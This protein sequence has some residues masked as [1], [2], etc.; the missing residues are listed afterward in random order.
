MRVLAV[1]GATD[2]NSPDARANINTELN[3]LRDELERIGKVTN[4]NGTT[5]LDGSASGPRALKFQ[6]GANGDANNR[7]TVDLKDADVTAISKFG[8]E[9]NE[10]KVASAKNRFA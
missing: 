6:V 2:S 7:I 8:K 5:L 4:F 10:S 9:A 1:Q 3:Q